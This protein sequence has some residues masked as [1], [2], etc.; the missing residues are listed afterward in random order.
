MALSGIDFLDIGHGSS[1]VKVSFFYGLTFE[2]FFVC[3]L[4]GGEEE[5]GVETAERTFECLS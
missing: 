1:C 3:L 2:V 5:G 4:F